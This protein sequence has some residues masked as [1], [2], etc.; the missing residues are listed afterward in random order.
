MEEVVWCRRL[1]RLT[2]PSIPSSLLAKMEM[3]DGTP[4]DSRVAANAL[5]LLWGRLHQRIFPEGSPACQGC[6]GGRTLYP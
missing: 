4:R 2:I 5:G 1:S 6:R 3:K